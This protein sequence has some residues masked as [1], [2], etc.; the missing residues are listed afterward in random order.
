MVPAGEITE[1]AAAAGREVRLAEAAEAV[2]MVEAAVA[3]DMVIVVEAV[4]AV[5]AAAVGMAIVEVEVEAEPEVEEEAQLQSSRKSITETL[6][7]TLLLTLC[8]DPR[9][10]S[11]QVDA[12]ITKIEDE[13]LKQL[14]QG[15][16]ISRLSIN[17]DGSGLFARRPGFATRGKNVILRANYI[18]VNTTKN[19]VIYRYHIDV[20]PEATGRKLKRIIAILLKDPRFVT[21][22]TDFRALLVTSAPLPE[23]PMEMEVVYLGEGEDE[24]L[25]NARPYRVRIQQTGV[26][27]VST[28]V[29]DLKQGTFNVGGDSRKEMVQALNL[30]VGRYPSSSPGITTLTNSRHYPFDAN[31][32][33]HA[34]GG[35]LSAVRGYFRSVRLATSRIML[36]INVS[37]LVTYSALPLTELMNRFGD[38]NG[39]DRQM[40][41]KFLRLVRIETTHLPV[42]KN[43]AGQVIPRVKTILALAN[44]GDGR[45]LAHPPKISANGA[46]PRDVEFYVDAQPEAAPG[47]APSKKG[48]KKKGGAPPSSRSAPSTGYISVYNFFKTRR[49]MSAWLLS[50]GC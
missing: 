33:V 48:A 23:T 30:M 17:P 36:N 27:D 7:L 20:V 19:L 31:A 50:A 29:A 1:A 38:Q 42:K 41:Q 3:V 10:P 26:L 22:A 37:H 46:G 35:G 25:P 47:T 21:P 11:P 40:L 6:M 12:A 49:C 43:K 8:S 16:D 45:K 44:K 39:F 13:R 32:V 14:N 2:D 24:P 34:L 4:I 9:D 18:A 5:E 28:L 15:L